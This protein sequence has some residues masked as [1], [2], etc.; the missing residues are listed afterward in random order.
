MRGSQAE[1]MADMGLISK[2]V[3]KLPKW[4]Q[5]TLTILAIVACVYGIARGGW[6]FVWRLIFSPD[7]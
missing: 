4:A 3:E 1:I 2:A 6:S 5:I 7:L